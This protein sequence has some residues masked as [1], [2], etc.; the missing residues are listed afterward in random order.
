VPDED[1]GGGPVTVAVALGRLGETGDL[2]FR[3]ILAGPQL[4]I[5]QPTRRNCSIYGGWLD[6]LETEFANSLLSRGDAA[7]RGGPKIRRLARRSANCENSE[8]YGST[9]GL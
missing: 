3:Q 8:A 9:T 7:L 4:G 6:Q 2:R 5:W 1:H